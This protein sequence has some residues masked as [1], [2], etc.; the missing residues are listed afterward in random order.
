MTMQR[1][2]GPGLATKLLLVG[3][4]LLL[5]PW[6]VL[7][8]LSAM[9]QF[10]FDGQA[11]AQLLVAQSVATLLNG[12]DE[13][14][15]DPDDP[16]LLPS[17][18]IHSLDGQIMLDGYD[19]DWQELTDKAQQFQGQATSFSLVLA[20]SEDQLLGLVR[21]KDDTAIGRHPAYLRLDHSDHLRLYLA[22]SEKH[23]QR[24][25]LSFEGTG[26]T[27]NY[28]MD[29]R[30]SFAEPGKP[31]Y[32]V[33][34]F[35]RR[36]PDTY[37]LEFS[38]PMSWLK[39]EQ[40]GVGIV[41]VIDSD[42]RRPNELIAS[43]GQWRG[44]LNPLVLR[45]AP[46]QAILEGL[47]P[48]QTRIWVIDSQFRVR[49]LRGDLKNTAGD[50]LIAIGD[51]QGFW[52]QATQIIKVMLTNV[53]V[54][55]PPRYFSD[56]NSE[57]TYFRKDPIVTDAL[58]GQAGTVKRPSL[59]E[60]T[61]IIAAAHPI[62]NGDQ[63]IGSILVEQSTDQLLLLQRQS[64]EKIY[65]LALLST[66]SIVL[67]LL[68]F[69]A[70]LA[71]RIRRLGRHTSSL[72]DD[73]GRMQNASPNR[74]ARA[75]D[76]LGELAR[77]FDA[78]T[79]RLA[80]HQDFLASIP[81]TLRHEINNPLSTLS[82]SLQHIQADPQSA[83]QYIDSAQ[84]A[85]N[86]IGLLVEKLSEAA[87][88]ENALKTERF[89]N[90]DLNA[91]LKTYVH[92]RQKIST[93]LYLADDFGN[94]P[95][96]ISGSDIHIEQMLDKLVDNALDFHTEGS[97]IKIALKKHKNQLVLSIRNEGPLIEGEPEQL[98]QLM[99]SSRSTDKQ[100]GEH[101]GLGLFI[102]RIIA[103]HH[104]GKISMSNQTTPDGVAV[105]ISLP[106]SAHHS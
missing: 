62:Y 21:V 27:T 106:A 15:T 10:L 73:H 28:S 89:Q 85:V 4:I 1:P 94:E 46:T 38:L 78:V 99:S 102:A 100:Q 13:L 7:Q 36:Q 72:I 77:N 95:A 84:R 67:V 64:I 93:D 47:S 90:L 105:E 17:L 58:A 42:N 33:R 11:Q 29:R 75:S 19:E 104:G 45:S 71:W 35:V 87:S 91:L 50:E 39:A 81:R 22:N 6:L 3:S 82:T 69:A 48:P 59:D 8:S 60:R 23:P 61:T 41:D 74:E 101:H 16:N 18:P 88:L 98:F 56:Y 76:E 31:L 97:S 32:Q 51:E 79:E 66:G 57:S 92:Y 26:R 52:R 2:R 12:R 53:L 9:K 83:S 25:A 37:T 44:E 70:R 86:R 43:F 54:G 20:Q 49:A 34:G 65:L 14:F 96:F 24:I 55:N 103:E 80:Q 30:W 68:A 5:V 63:I 40:L